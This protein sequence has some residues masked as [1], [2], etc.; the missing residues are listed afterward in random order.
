MNW[1]LCENMFARTRSETSN[2]DSITPST[3]ITSPFCMAFII[4]FNE[5]YKINHVELIK[6]S[7]IN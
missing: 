4:D 1:V 5:Y 6:I 2:P 7:I 3:N